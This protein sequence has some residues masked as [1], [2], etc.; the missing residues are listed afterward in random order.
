[1][2]NKC[3]Q[4]LYQVLTFSSGIMIIILL[5]DNSRRFG[6]LPLRLAKESWFA[7][8]YFLFFFW[9]LLFLFTIYASIFVKLYRWENELKIISIIFLLA[10]IPRL[11]LVLLNFEFYI[12]TSDFLYYFNFGQWALEGNYEAIAYRIE[13]YRMPRMGGLAIYNGLIARLFSPTIVGFQISNV[14]TTSLICVFIYLVGKEINRKVALGASMFFTLYLSNIVSTQI[15]LNQHPMVLYLLV[16]MYLFWKFKETN[17]KSLS[18]LYLSLSVMFFGVA[19]FLHASFLVFLIAY[20]MFAG[21]VFLAS[22]DKNVR[23]RMLMFRVRYISPKCKEMLLFV[24]V[25]LIGYMVVSQAGLQLM[26]QKGVINS[27]EVHPFLQHFVVGLDVET[28]GRVTNNESLERLRSY[29]Y[30]ERQAMAVQIIREQLSNP[31][32][33][34]RLVLRKTQIAWLEP[35]THFFWYINYYRQEYLSMREEGVQ[36]EQWYERRDS[37]H[38]MRRL[39]GEVA[40]VDQ[41][42]V[43]ILFFF[44]A[45]GLLLKKYSKADDIYYLQL[46]I[47]IGMFAIIGLG[48]AQPRYRYPAMPSLAILGSFGFFEVLRLLEVLKEKISPLANRMTLNTTRK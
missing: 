33:V 40:S 16:S 21:I 12:P 46:I 5:V 4:R 3:I 26:L 32:E 15:T 47:V 9:V 18:L 38:D 10:A 8:S 42:V 19:S 36:G 43:Q 7:N 44:V 30:E 22:V 17:K 29:P 14:I 2:T 25:F 48:E 23:N 13:R 37:F 27:L 11:L 20:T 35:D 45:L 41:L 39:S 31:E 24:C 6:W 34:I 28:N 1:M